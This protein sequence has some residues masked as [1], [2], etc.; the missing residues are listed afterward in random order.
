MSFECSFRGGQKP[1]H[2]SIGGS[3]PFVA[4][5]ASEQFV[6]LSFSSSSFAIQC[7]CKRGFL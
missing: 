7:F 2:E 6:Y 5:G 4:I 1:G 3:N